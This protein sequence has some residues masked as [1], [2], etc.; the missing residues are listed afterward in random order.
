MEKQQMSMPSFSSLSADQRRVYNLYK[1]N[2]AHLG[3]QFFHDFIA[4]K[5]R[6]GGPLPAPWEAEAKIMD[7]VIEL[8]SSGGDL[9]LFR[10][11]FDD[12]VARFVENDIYRY[13]TYM[14][15][16]TDRSALERHWSGGA[17]RTPVLLEI[18]CR[19]GTHMI[20]GELNLGHGGYE[21][22]MI[23]GRGSS[24][25]I[26]SQKNITEQAEIVA[27]MGTFYSRDV[28]LLR[29]YEIAYL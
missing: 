29:T 13:P 3:Q 19:G 16:S 12:F 2:G 11:T 18:N 7:S 20:D 27:A 22:E 28:T 17:G 9:V 10:A 26:L 25:Q 14:S 4:D 5:L 24:F 8:G 15:T 1:A 23:L 6:S 21:A